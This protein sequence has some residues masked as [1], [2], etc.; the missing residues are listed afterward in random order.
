MCRIC[1]ALFLAFLPSTI[2]S[3]D[4]LGSDSISYKYYRK[5][6]DRLVVA[7]FQSARSYGLEI[8]QTT[9]TDSLGVSKLNYAADANEVTGI[10]LDYDKLSISFGIKSKPQDARKGKTKY[11]QL[12][13]SFGGNRWRLE[14][15]LFR[16][17][18]F[19][20]KN[21]YRYD[22]SYTETSPF[23]SISDMRSEGI[24]TK[25]LYFFNYKK[26]SFPASYSCT[27]RQMKTALTWMVSGNFFYNRLSADSSFV[28][29]QVAE[30]YSFNSR[31]NHLGMTGVSF[32]A[33][34]SA[35]LVLLRALFANLTFV[36]GP[37]MQWRR[38]GYL[39][40][41]DESLAYMTASGDFRA[42]LGYNGRD[43]FMTLTSLTDFRATNGRGFNVSSK[44]VS[45]ALTIGYRF[46]VKDPRFMK[47]VRESKVYNLF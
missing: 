35:N 12:G 13:V 21:T 1:V 46:K 10:E 23:F 20:D 43:F 36:V 33:G 16:Y 47:T 31:L 30:L 45:G 11:S 5:Y 40:R 26:F 19:Y 44:F 22:T 39:D 7:L 2:F 29:K 18:G 14:T 42:A 34:F 38:Y 17:V 3:Q 25:F 41:K 32:A 6:S 9:L 8:S 15:A 4:T 37:E 27:Y 28:P 24:K